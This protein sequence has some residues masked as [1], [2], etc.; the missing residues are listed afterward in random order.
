MVWSSEELSKQIEL[1]EDSRVEFKEA[2]F[3]DNRVREPHRDTI[4][5]ELAAL[6]NTVGGTL[7]F[8]V[9]DC[10]EIRPMNRQQMDAL[11]TYVAEICSDSIDPALA[12]VTQRLSLLAGS[13]VLVVE[14]EQSQSVHRSPGG[15]LRRQGSTT[16]QIPSEALHRLFQQRG[17]SGQLGPDETVVEGSGRNSLDIDLVDKFMSSRS[18]ESDVAQLMKLGMIRDDDNGIARATIAGVLFCTNR[19]DEY[20]S[21]A[22]IEAVRYRGTI[23]GR[24][25]QH[26]A[27]SITGPLNQQIREAVNF[28]RRNTRVA[29]QKVPGRVESPQF[30]PRAVF[31]AI[32]NAAVHRDYS[33]ENAKIRVFIFDDRLEIYS[34]GSLPNT[35]PIEAMRSRQ[36]TRNETVSSLLRMLTIGD[37]YGSGDRQYFLELRGEGVPVIFE[38]T[39]NLTGRNPEYELIGGAE[40]KLTIPSTLPPTEGIK[41]GISVVTDRAPLSKADVVVHYPNKT[42]QKGK[43]DTFG[44]VDFEF[45]S[46]LPI[47]VFCAAPGHASYV[48][49]NWRPPEPLSIQLD[50][51]PTGGS[52]IFTEETGHL[53]KLTGRLNPILD[54]L[55]RMYLYATNIAIDEGKQQPVHFKLNHPLRL[56]DVSG[57]EWIVRFTDMIGKSAILEYEKP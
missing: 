28:T 25:D 31:E 33:I 56:T 18:T 13:S 2:V 39:L 30:S 42:W 43:T 37:I 52:A 10:G 29:A 49:R 44:R 23:L 38:E 3:A 40:L 21:G 11:E 50:K 5:N 14:I 34:P 4:A 24:S 45:H 20:I 17:R 26:D 55:E 19:P 9:S 36:A 53:P 47:T 16:R 41:G 48:E 1:G 54:N 22:K 46:L 12:Y 57:F 51:L 15:Y 32:V 7:I 35:L 27:I 8:S 6:G